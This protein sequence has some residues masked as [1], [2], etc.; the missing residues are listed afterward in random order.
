MATIDL[1]NAT[2]RIKDGYTGPAGSHA[3]NNSGGYSIGAVTMVVDGFTGAVAVHDWFTVAGDV[4]TRGNLVHHRITAHTETLGNTTSIT[5]T[6][7][8]VV[9]VVDDAVVTVLPHELEVK[10]GEGNCT[11]DE[12]FAR[13]YKLNRGKLN[14]VR[15]GD[16][17]PMDVS[18]DF[19][20][21]FLKANTGQQP[22]VEDALKK[23]GQAAA[24][25]SS[26]ADS[27]EPYAVDIEIEYT[28][29]CGSEDLE[30]ITLPD[31]RVEKLSHN[32]KDGTVACT[33]K[34]NATEAII[35]RV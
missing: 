10:V 31:F 15:D 1:K 23:R 8:L 34:C 3:V 13:E 26:S 21:E 5:F 22:S 18:L 12:T 17:T 11:Y 14:T 25:I 20:W 2:I 4:D 16:D 24:W 6:P 33:G 19:E 35:S 9:A 7:A 30:I 29:P 27:C 32:P 28:P